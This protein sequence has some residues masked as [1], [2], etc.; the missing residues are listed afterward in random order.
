MRHA[1]A[2]IIGGG[3]SGLSTAYWL[4][5]KGMRDI[6]V[7]D[8]SYL[9]SGAT[10]RCLGGI[11]AQFTNEPDILIALYSEQMYETLGAELGFDPLFRQ[12]GYLFMAFDDKDLEMYRR[13]SNVQNQFGVFSRIVTTSEMKRLAPALNTRHLVGG[14]WNPKDGNAVHF[15]VTNGLA[16]R[17]RK[18]GA[19]IKPFTSVLEIETAGGRVVGVQTSEGAIRTNT[20]ICAAGIHSMM[21][22]EP[23]GIKLPLRP[24]KQEVLVTEPIKPFLDPMLVSVRGHSIFQTM[25]GD[26]VAEC[27]DKREEN[28]DTLAWDSTFSFLETCARKLLEVL[29]CLR[30]VPV[31]R[32]W[33][34]TYDTSPD[35]RPILQAFSDPQGLLLC[36]GYSGHGFML[37]PMVGKIMAELA[38]DG[39][40][41]FDIS[42]FSLERFTRPDL[43]VE[44]LVI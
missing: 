29:P 5:K 39:A 6:V 23:L 37:A 1:D 15:A 35:H 42:T 32:Q 26:I 36:A 25:R 27:S 44:T 10:G 7:L 14:C 3:S 22:L 11:R 18:L 28:A 41:T 30:D 34:G 16:E 12:G 13:N 9:S 4:T 21:L 24:R 17:A 19:V 31:Q 40:S 33:A 2:V 20:V 8:R 38:I 43:Q